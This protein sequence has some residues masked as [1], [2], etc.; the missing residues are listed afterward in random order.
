MEAI[1]PK[2]VIVIVL[3]GFVLGCQTVD[4]SM[5]L[6]E[7]ELRAQEDQ[8]YYLDRQVDRLCAQ[9]A[10]CRKNNQS[11]RQ[12]LNEKQPSDARPSSSPSPATARPNAA[13]G[14]RPTAPA[15][16]P[17]SRPPASATPPP[18]SIDPD[19][20]EIPEIDLGP[21]AEGVDE[22]N[23]GS[24]GLD[25]AESLDDQAVNAQVTRIV[26]NSRL[27]GGYD[28][29]GQP[30]DE[31]IM[32]V[33]EPQ[34]SAGQYVALPGDLS[35]IVVDPQSP[36]PMRELA[37]WE[38]DASETVPW[39]KKTLLGRGIHL[40][41]PW[42][43]QP[44]SSERLQLYVRYRTAAGEELLAQRE[45]RV[46]LVATRL[47]A[48]L[49][50]S[51]PRP[52]AAI[53]SDESFLPNTTSAAHD[54]LSSQALIPPRA[55]SVPGTANEITSRSNGPTWSPYPAISRANRAAETHPSG[56]RTRRPQWQP[57]R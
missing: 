42:P 45:V 30:G 46:D 29:D 56:Q 28:E 13:T 40:Q 48:D 21:D 12:Q 8:I 20:L 50:S 54:L 22:A 2:V 43:N 16:E 49:S 52:A 4:P 37:R 5:E 23:P 24:P 25:A 1:P 41:L 35:V 32:V 26:L 39:L 55:P 11:L 18:S 53:A 6:L 51:A 3:L 36:A 14:E 15:T 38:F 47:P 9:L 19:D 27:T 17:N 7:S 10:S 31:A 33:I 34:N 57:F 44:P